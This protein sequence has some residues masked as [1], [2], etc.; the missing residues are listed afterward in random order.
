MLDAFAA[1]LAWG[2]PGGI[3]IFFIGLGVLL[4]GVSKLEQS[5]SKS[6]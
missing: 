2:T 4:W 3:A 6:K 1:P 5:K